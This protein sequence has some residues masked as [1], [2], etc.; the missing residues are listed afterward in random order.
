MR[1]YKDLIVWQ[2]AVE[3][4]AATYALVHEYPRDEIFG[5]TSQMKRAALSIPANI[6]EGSGRRTE[7]DFRHFL[8]IAYG[9][10]LELET[11]ITIGKRFGFGKIHNYSPVEHLLT[12]IL[13]MLHKMHM[14]NITPTKPLG[15]ED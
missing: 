7:K 10:A 3:L 1:G 5:I 15:T 11:F 9:S 8:A 4:V 12:E 2:K 14:K 13:K 6:A